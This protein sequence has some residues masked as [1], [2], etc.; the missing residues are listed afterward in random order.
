ML[1]AKAIDNDD[2]PRRER[3]SGHLHDN[4]VFSPRRPRSTDAPYLLYIRP[5][6]RC[7]NFYCQEY[8]PVMLTKGISSYL[9]FC[10]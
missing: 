3:E 10:K 4:G 8:L 2:A 1:Y 5:I 9:S 7:Y 6:Q